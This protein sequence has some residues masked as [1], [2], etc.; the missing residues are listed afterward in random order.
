MVKKE[1]YIKLDFD[2]SAS[3]FSELPQHIEVEIAFVGAS[4]AGKSSLLNAISNNKKIAKT[5]KSPGKTKLFNFFKAKSGVIVDLPGYGFSKVSKI[6]KRQWS[7][8]IPKYFSSREN[9]KYVFL[10]S[11]CR[12]ALKKVDLDMI[13]ILESLNLCYQ[14]VLTKSDKLN[15][16][17]KAKAQQRL[18]DQR[19][20]MLFSIKDKESV[21][22]LISKINVLLSN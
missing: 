15:K 12:T 16:R 8:E 9:L 18:K 1:K 4:N 14:I 22:N 6:Q 5:S 7:G 3:N 21:F 11:D 13:D 17:E 20:M 19:S 10:V 2:V